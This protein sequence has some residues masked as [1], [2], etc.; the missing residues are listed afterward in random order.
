MAKLQYLRHGATRQERVGVISRCVDRRSGTRA[1]CIRV[2]LNAAESSEMLKA[3]YR[4]MRTPCRC[5]LLENW[6]ELPFR[7]DAHAWVVE[8]ANRRPEH[9]QRAEHTLIKCRLF[10]GMFSAA[11]GDSVAVV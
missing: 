7:R 9:A 6:A 3:V 5:S 1:S 2:T 11:V 8:I 10:S 4:L